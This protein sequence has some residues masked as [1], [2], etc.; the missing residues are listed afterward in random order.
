MVLAIGLVAFGAL[1]AWRTGFGDRAPPRIR[2][3][4][5]GARA[6]D[7]ATVDRLQ[8]L[9]MRFGSDA[10]KEPTVNL[11]SPSDADFEFL[12]G[13]VAARGPASSVSAARVLRD[14][15]SLRSVGPLLDAVKG[16]DEID[17]FFLECAFR[18]LDAATPEARV[19]MLVPSWERNRETWTG[20]VVTAMRLKLRDSG[21]LD[22]GFLRETA[23]AHVD[24]VFRRFALRELADAQ[25]APAGLLAAALADPDADVRALAAAGLGR[26]DRR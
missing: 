3:L 13:L 16:T 21:A 24:P 18:I 23:T 6:V 14:I 1:H 5:E 9:G 17:R 19:A 22:P 11:D 15:G 12:E 7:R 20:P 8:S 4:L 2:A 25:A 10:P 26:R